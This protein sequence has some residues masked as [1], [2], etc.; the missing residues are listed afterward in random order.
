MLDVIR[1]HVLVGLL[2]MSRANHNSKEVIS[3]LL[4]RGKLWVAALEKR[5]LIQRK[6]QNRQWSGHNVYE[7]SAIHE[8]T[9]AGKLI[10]ELLKITG[11]FIES[12]NAIQRKAAEKVANMRKRP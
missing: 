7:I 1:L 3:E 10:A 12:D 6:K 11:I 4:V 5:G 9:E 8:L 2:D